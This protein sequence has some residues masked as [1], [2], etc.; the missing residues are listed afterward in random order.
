V[1]WDSINPVVCFSGK[2]PDC[3]KPELKKSLPE[4][5][6]DDDPAVPP[7][8]AVETARFA[9]N[10]PYSFEAETRF[11]LVAIGSSRNAE[12]AVQTT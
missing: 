6:R 4:K 8:L 2:K 5:G 12:A 1:K 3:S 9:T 10:S 11:G 7:C